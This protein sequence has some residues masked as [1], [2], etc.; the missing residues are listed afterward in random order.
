MDS[1]I[2]LWLGSDHR[3]QGL[4]EFVWMEDCVAC[5]NL[6]TSSDDDVLYIGPRYSIAGKAEERRE[7][8][9][10]CLRGSCGWIALCVEGLWAECFAIWMLHK[11]GSY[12]V[13]CCGICL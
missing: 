11:S 8:R 3:P 2:G 12:R 1:F 9:Q 13:S 10:G 5:C 6:M 4:F 7:V